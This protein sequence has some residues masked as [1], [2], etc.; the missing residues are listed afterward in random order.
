MSAYTRQFYRCCQWGRSYIWGLCT[1]WDA[2]SWESGPN[3]WE[4]PCFSGSR[5]WGHWLPIGDYWGN[6]TGTRSSCFSASYACGSGE[7]SYL[8]A[9]TKRKFSF[10][11]WVCFSK[12]ARTT[13]IG[14]SA[15]PNGIKLLT[16]H[17]HQSLTDNLW[18]Q[19]KRYVQE[20]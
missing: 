2:L 20:I 10:D 19:P 14:F 3:S 5:G 8:F 11:F 13:V 1:V 4:N 17:Y 16:I 18:E 12:K 6:E 9:R 15:E 7:V